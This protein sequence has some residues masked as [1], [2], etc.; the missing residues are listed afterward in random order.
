MIKRTSDLISVLVEMD[1]NYFKYL[2][3][4]ELYFISDLVVNTEISN[5]FSVSFPTAFKSDIDL[6]VH[7]LF[8]TEK[9]HDIILHTNIN[10]N[11]LA[12]Q[13]DGKLDDY[14]TTSLGG[15]IELKDNIVQFLLD[16]LFIRYNDFDIRNKELID[17]AYSDDK[18][19]FN[20]FN[21]T[22]SPGDIELSGL[23]SLTSDQNLS[24][25]I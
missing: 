1:V 18:V 25:N 14:L 2:E 13:F 17:V 19:Y 6:S 7:Q 9:F 11:R 4:D 16:S 8:L 23:F 10:Q 12:L 15:N 24:L 3:G 5:D 20:N 22:H 21:M